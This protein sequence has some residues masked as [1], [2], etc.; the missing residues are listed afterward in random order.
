MTDT[1]PTTTSPATAPLPG[2]KLFAFEPLPSA[3]DWLE[4]C[5]RRYPE[6][7]KLIWP[8]SA[9]SFGPLEV[10]HHQVLGEGW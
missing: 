8:T 2:V 7:G 9:L 5:L 6:F 4:E 1:D 10:L 3:A